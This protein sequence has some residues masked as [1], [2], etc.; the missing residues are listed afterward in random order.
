M[1]EYKGSKLPRIVI[2]VGDQGQTRWL[3]MEWRREN[4]HSQWGQEPPRASP[5]KEAKQNNL[6]WT[7]KKRRKVE[8]NPHNVNDKEDEKM[9]Y[10]AMKK[11]D[12][13]NERKVIEK[14]I[15]EDV[16]TPSAIMPICQPDK[17]LF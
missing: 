16:Y 1:I 11:K 17:P 12:D 4:E 10:D 9:I 15:N 2:E 5:R 13:K 6:R 14:N 8:A 3:K 7:P